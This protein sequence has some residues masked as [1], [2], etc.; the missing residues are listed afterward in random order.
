MRST[1]VQSSVP[2][3]TRLFISLIGHCAGALPCGCMPA[4]LAH[5]VAAAPAERSL[6]VLADNEPSGSVTR[7][8]A[9]CSP[10]PGIHDRGEPG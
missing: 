4:A 6:A 3:A 7:A 2:Y 5:P 1:W 10:R 8:A 9:R